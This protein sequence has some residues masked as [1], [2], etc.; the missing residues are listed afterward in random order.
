[1]SPCEV[2]QGRHGE[3]IVALCLADDPDF[4]QSS[5]RPRALS[6]RRPT[7]HLAWDKLHEV[8]GR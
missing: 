1:M 4:L 6:V 2:E 8:L 7:E 5:S 3:V